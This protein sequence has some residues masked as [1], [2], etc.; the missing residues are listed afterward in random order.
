MQRPALPVTRHRLTSGL[1]PL[2]LMAAGVAFAQQ[3]DFAAAIA[4]W[5]SELS[6]R[7]LATASRLLQRLSTSLARY[8]GRDA[9][10]QPA[11][12]PVPGL[13]GEEPP[14]D[15]DHLPSPAAADA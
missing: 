9:A 14:P 12:D 11:V 6:A 13:G 2:L 7:D 5:M 3:G 8:E 1:L 10:A 15:A 4:E